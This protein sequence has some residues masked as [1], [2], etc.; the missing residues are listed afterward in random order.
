MPEI[1]PSESAKIESG[2][3]KPEIFLEK[4]YKE[5]NKAW[6]GEKILTGKNGTIYLISE[7]RYFEGSGVQY[8]LILSKIDNSG[9]TLFNLKF[10]EEDLPTEHTYATISGKELLITGKCGTDIL[11]IKADTLGNRLAYKRYNVRNLNTNGFFI[12]S[13][14]SGYQLYGYGETI[15]GMKYIV[16][17]LL[18]NS[19][20]KKLE[21]ILR[22][23]SHSK[24][25]I[26]KIIKVPGG[27]IAAGTVDIKSLFSNL[28]IT[29]YDESGRIVFEKSAGG[30]KPEK[31]S[32]IMEL[33]NG[34]ILLAGSTRSFT[35]TEDYYLVK[36]DKYGKQLWERF[37]GGNHDDYNP[38][39]FV[40]TNGNI[41]LAGLSLF[42]NSSYNR[43][44]VVFIEKNGN[45]SADFYLG[46]NYSQDESKDRISY[47][48]YDIKVISGNTL[49]LTGSKD[50]YYFSGVEKEM[51]L[52]KIKY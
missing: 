51:L 40:D 8:N 28:Y 23:E 41:K 50:Y 35:M 45:K 7:E 38:K 27:Y 39:I 20:N 13:S 48:V 49:I 46:E 10:A 12:K 24:A 2:S 4:S 15:N 47:S 9:K 18:D 33:P 1:L 34:D 5:E 25:N 30:A 29:K 19:G 6:E 11:F 22:I 26:E 14:G 37:Y 36:Y 21:D 16:K 17:M 43:S 32:D 44:Y 31:F 52:M 42:K 3:F